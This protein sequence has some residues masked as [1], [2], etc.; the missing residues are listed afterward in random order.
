MPYS[1][2]ASATVKSYLVQRVLIFD[3]TNLERLLSINFHNE[4]P[5]LHMTSLKEPT[6]IQPE[7]SRVCFAAIKF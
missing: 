3:Y 6:E 2:T 1:A 4:T 5:T 7:E